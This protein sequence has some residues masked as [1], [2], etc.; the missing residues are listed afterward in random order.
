MS[1]TTNLHLTLPAWSDSFE[2]DDWN[3]NMEK[4]DNFAGQVGGYITALQAAAAGVFGVGT[5]ITATSENIADL[6]AMTTP[7][8]YQCSAAASP[9]VSNQPIATNPPGFSM[10]IR[11]NGMDTHVS[12]SISYDAAD[13]AAYRY[14]RIK[15]VSGWSPWYRFTGEAVV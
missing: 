3:G 9:Y 14:E 10:I 2:L 5:S 7:G 1:Q 15:T 13:Q 11:T 4:I 12:Q 8:K 6:D